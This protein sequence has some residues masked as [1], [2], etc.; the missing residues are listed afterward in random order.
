[1][2]T[3]QQIAEVI[4]SGNSA[5]VLSTERGAG[6]LSSIRA[7]MPTAHEMSLPEPADVAGLPEGPALI[8]LVGVQEV[9]ET[10]RAAL[11]VAMQARQIIV[12]VSSPLELMERSV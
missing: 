2:S 5:V 10:M 9:P 11:R 12:V 4:A 3:I 8:D 7:L 1:M 6:H